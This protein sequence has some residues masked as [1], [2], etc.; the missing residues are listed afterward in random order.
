MYLSIKLTSKLIK[1]CSLVDKV[2]KA[3]GFKK[4]IKKFHTY[5]YLRIEDNIT[6]GNYELQVPFQVIHHGKKESLYKIHEIIILSKSP[7]LKNQQIPSAIIHAANEKFREVSSYLI[8][9]KTRTR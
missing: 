1:P 9:S 8:D 3:Q 7:L 5:Y 4:R 2:F 6:R